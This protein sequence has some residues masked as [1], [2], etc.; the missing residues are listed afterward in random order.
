MSFDF[1]QCN[2]FLKE[3]FKSEYDF[4]IDDLIHC[5]FHQE[6]NGLSAFLQEKLAING[7]WKV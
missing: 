7:L 3:F 1:L 2:N 4:V 6:Y 5:Y